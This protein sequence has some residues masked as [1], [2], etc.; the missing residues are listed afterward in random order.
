[1]A[2]RSRA[3]VVVGG[4]VLT[5]ALAAPLA[6]APSR[7]ARLAPAPDSALGVPFIP[8]GELLCGGAAAAMV[9]RYHG[10]RGVGAESFAQLVRRDEGGIRTDELAAALRA[11]GWR[12]EERVGDRDALARALAAGLPPIVLLES[13]RGRWHYVVVVA[14]D[15][16]GARVHDPARAPDLRVE[17]N[18]FMARWEGGERWMLLVGPRSNVSVAAA[19]SDLEFGGGAVEDA[20]VHPDLVRAS[21]HFRA[22]QWSAAADAA[23]RATGAAPADPRAWRLLGTAR[24]LAGEPDAALAAWARAG[25]ARVDGVVVHGLART[26]H[27]VVHALLGLSPGAPL[28]ADLLALARRRVA[29][30]PSAARTRVHYR[31]LADGWVEVEASVLESPPHPFS[32]AGLA[33]LGAAAAAGEGRVR[34]AGLLGAGERLDLRWRPEAGGHSFGLELAAPGALGLGGRVEA[35]LARIALEQSEYRSDHVSAWLR[36]TDWATA[37][38]RWE[39]GA[40]ADRDSALRPAATGALELA[41]ADDRALVT[42]ALAFWPSFA[43]RAASTLLTLDAALAR[44]GP[45]DP[46][47]FAARAGVR[48][49][50]GPVP[51]TFL[52]GTDATPAPALGGAF[53]G[54]DPAPL[55]RAHAPVQGSKVLHVGVEGTGWV[56]GALRLG[57]AAFVDAAA[58]QDAAVPDRALAAVG[59]GLRVAVPGLDTPL[60]IDHA[61]DPA[62]GSG[63]WS[64]GLAFA[65][66]RSLR[67]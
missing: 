12:A 55:L 29:L 26:R 22:Q 36:A 48:A 13:A 33:V 42:G 19:E 54:L 5:A 34:L 52:P 31:A 9:L 59:A 17:W 46:W 39:L 43:G 24:Y 51:Q 7:S 21:M 35:G 25:E 47:S 38:L 45:A 3:R 11:R 20:L 62:G 4:A 44:G 2:P 57:I 30:L 15:E 64:A 8:Q 49:A 63:R 40:R 32:P 16:A 60:R 18:E 66:G 1:M 50:R 23:E 65:P 6:G 58:V 27:P 41:R 56:G 10:A 53:M 14:M 28:D 67:P 61:W 37:W